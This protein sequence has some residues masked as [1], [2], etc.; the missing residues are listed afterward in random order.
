MQ[1][2]PTVR[3]SSYLCVMRQIPGEI[4]Q[5]GNNKKEEQSVCKKK[6]KEKAK[7][8]FEGLCADNLDL[9]G[10]AAVLDDKHE[11]AFFLAKVKALEKQKAIFSRNI[12]EIN[13]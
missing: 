3:T 12:A 4:Q 2:C 9:E 8:R 5:K 6:L 11:E 10:D 7:Q 13:K 1:L